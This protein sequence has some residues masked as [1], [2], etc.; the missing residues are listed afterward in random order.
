MPLC[1]VATSKALRKAQW[2]VF[3]LSRNHHC[4][5][6]L[7]GATRSLATLPNVPKLAEQK[8]PLSIEEQ[9]KQWSKP[10]DFLR[11]LNTHPFLVYTTWIDC[12]TERWD[13][14]TGEETDL[15]I[16]IPLAVFTA[17]LFGPP[18]LIVLGCGYALVYGCGRAAGFL[19]GVCTPMFILMAIGG[20]IYISGCLVLGCDEKRKMKKSKNHN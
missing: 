11:H 9:A 13:L 20:V 16:F 7:P 3:V 2:S 8:T 19:F 17:V 5:P 12:S 1:P 10:S 15:S 14:L 18:G 6:Q 4:R